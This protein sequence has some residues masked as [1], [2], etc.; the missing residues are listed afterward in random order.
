MNELVIFFIGVFV[1]FLGVPLGI[2][3]AKFTK[4]E[5]K[6]GRKWFK[7]L[8]ITSLVVGMVGLI[9]RNDGLMFSCFFI[10]LITAQSLNL[11]K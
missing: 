1:L 5:L 4:E 8:I 10:A 3:L 2:F 7:I 11:K 6:D 9:I